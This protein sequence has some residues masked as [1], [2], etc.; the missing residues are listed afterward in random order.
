[1][2]CFSPKGPISVQWLGANEVGLEVEEENIV[3]TLPRERSFRSNI[4]E[5]STSPLH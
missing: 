3:A 5:M 4:T 2:S 1:M